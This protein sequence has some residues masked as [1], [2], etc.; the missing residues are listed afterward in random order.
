MTQPRQIHCARDLAEPE[1][2]SGSGDPNVKRLHPEGKNTPDVVNPVEAGDPRPIAPGSEDPEIG[3]DSGEVR[4]RLLHVHG[5][6]SCGTNIPL[7]IGPRS[8]QS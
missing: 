7:R 3:E 2:A 4:R 6:I 1:A 5:M 8:R